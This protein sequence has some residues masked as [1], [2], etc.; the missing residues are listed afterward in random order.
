MVIGKL[1]GSRDY[2]DILRGRD[3][4]DASE[5]NPGRA[6]STDSAEVNVNSGAV[7]KVSSPLTST[8]SPS[9]GSPSSRAVDR[10]SGD[11]DWERPTSS[12]LA[13]FIEKK[14]YE[15]GVS[16]PWEPIKPKPRVPLSIETAPPAAPVSSTR[17]ARPGDLFR[18]GS[19]ATEGVRRKSGS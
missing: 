17:S 18:R 19:Q 9:I 12:A 2:R 15:T 6:V 7:D 1:F 16:N 11:G 8:V 13:R 10:E 4:D 14:T 3:F 5:T